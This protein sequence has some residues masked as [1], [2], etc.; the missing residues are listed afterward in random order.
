[1][2]KWLSQE[3]LDETRRLA[4]SQPER[5]GASASIQYVVTGAPEGTIE[6]YWIL[7]DGKLAESSLGHLEGAEVT[8]TQAWQDAM[9]IQKGELDANAAFMQGRIKVTGDMA[10]LMALLPITTSAEYRELQ[11]EIAKITE[12]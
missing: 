7:I 2:P 11:E 8:L 9:E 3:W 1:M 4:Q 10:K 5:D 12:F 6:Y